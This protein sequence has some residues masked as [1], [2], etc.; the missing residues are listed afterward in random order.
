M[1]SYKTDW[2]KKHAKAKKAKQ[3]DANTSVDKFNKQHIAA[4]Q[5]K[6][7]NVQSIL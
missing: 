1:I 4:R 5:K 7:K 3:K 6:R 2:L